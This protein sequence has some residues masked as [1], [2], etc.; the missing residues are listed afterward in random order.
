MKPFHRHFFALFSTL[1]LLVT[2]MTAPVKAQ[3]FANIDSVSIALVTCEPH[4]EVYSLYGHTALRILDKS[5]NTDLTVNYGVFDQSKPYFVLR[6]ILGL[7][8][9]TMSIIPTDVFLREYMYYGSAVREQVLNLTTDEKQKFLTTLFDNYRPEN[10]IYR[11]NFY[12]NNCTTKAR[13][14]IIG[15]INGSVVYSNYGMQEGEK[16]FRELI[17]WK[18]EDYR[19]S[20]FGNDIL[21]GV[22]SDKNSSFYEREFLPEILMTDFDNAKIKDFKGTER[23]LV[24]Q[25]RWILQH[26]K[27]YANPMP[28]FPLTPTQCALLFLIITIAITAM[29]RLKV[30]HRLQFVD[31]TIFLMA[32]TIGL[33][34]T[35]MIF[36]EHPTVRINL[37][38]LAFSPLCFAMAYRKTQKQRLT[39]VII[40]STLLFFLGNTLQDYAEGM[41]I[42]ALSLLVRLLNIRF[43]YVKK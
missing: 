8:D 34:L 1:T 40:I 9:Y 10:R 25:S 35:A 2:S 17:H 43:D 39:N 36:S 38:I 5:S 27:S 13:D 22:G 23:P 14:I 12:Y 33:L 30:K 20:R 15:S 37:H 24:I 26:G 41:N 32:G 21:L 42:M 29:E 11:Y 28:G 16:T 7:T 6:F 19:W 4:E 18:N 3:P 31:T